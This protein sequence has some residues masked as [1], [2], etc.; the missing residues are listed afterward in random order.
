MMPKPRVGFFVF[1]GK[2][3]PGLDAMQ[4]GFFTE[5]VLGRAFGVDNASPCRH[6]VHRAWM[7]FLNAADNITIEHNV[8]VVVAKLYLMSY[9]APILSAI[10]RLC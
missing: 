8:F 1:I 10:S 3:Y 7:D 9:F 4:N 2:C 5:L 6:P